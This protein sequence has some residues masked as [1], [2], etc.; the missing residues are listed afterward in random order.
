MS[1]FSE[2]CWVELATLDKPKA[3]AFYADLFGWSVLEQPLGTPSGRI[4]AYAA[5]LLEGNPGGAV[6]ELIAEQTAGGIAPHWLSYVAVE[7][8]DQSTRRAEQLGGTPLLDPSD[9]FEAG[10]MSIIED[11]GG[12]KLGLWQAKN[13]AGFE[14]GQALGA[15]CWFELR[16]P[17]VER[18]RKFYGS[19]FG[20]EQRRPS[21][22]SALSL[23]TKGSRTLAGVTSLTDERAPSWTPHFAVASCDSSRARIQQAGGNPQAPA[24]DLP[25]VGRRLTALDP[26]GAPFAILEPRFAS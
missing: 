7:S 26:Q 20:W 4:L 21:G 14:P 24:T 12:A 17:D 11:P 2:F 13:L 9:V 8:V 16:T 6:Y 15:P 1:S 19:L 18:C 5:F 25:G 10:R 3:Q 23:I 22:P